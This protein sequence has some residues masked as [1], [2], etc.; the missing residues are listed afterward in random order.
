MSVPAAETL[1]NRPDPRV[2][3]N[4]ISPPGNLDSDEPP[5]ETNLH[6]DQIDLLIRLLR[7]IWRDCQD[8]YAS[9]NL[10]IYYSPHHG[11]HDNVLRFFTS[12]ERLVPTPE[13]RN[14]KLAA[15]LR[16]LGINPDEV[17]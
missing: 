9:G 7:E 11:I 1:E 13:E 15:K 2:S 14:E 12:D 3:Q 16:E 8:F 6:R 5:L 10:T 4:I 17:E